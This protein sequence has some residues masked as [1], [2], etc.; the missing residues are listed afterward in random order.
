MNIRLLCTVLLK[1][2]FTSNNQFLRGQDLKA[3]NEPSLLKT[4][5]P[6]L[7]GIKTIVGI[8]TF[9]RGPFT[10]NNNLIQI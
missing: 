10:F 2:R 8:K 6:S 9:L 7:M 3:N 4:M 5:K 1:L